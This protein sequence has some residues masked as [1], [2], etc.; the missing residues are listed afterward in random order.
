MKEDKLSLKLQKISSYILIVVAIL[1][2]VLALGFMTN[3]YQLFYNGTAE[4]YQYYK[5]IQG[6][7]HA[8]FQSAIIL[9]ILSLLQIP[10][11][12]T[13]KTTNI[14]GL[15]L[16]LITTIINFVNS[17]TVLKFNSYFKGLYKQLDFSSIESYTYSIRPFQLTSVL[18]IATIIL[19]IFVLGVSIFNYISTNRRQGKV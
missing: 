19:T 5:D 2:G 10:F 18:F 6:L 1:V 17:M 9:I 8:I 7:N 15:V 11:E 3:F 14:F 13:K 12:I 4:T 16:L